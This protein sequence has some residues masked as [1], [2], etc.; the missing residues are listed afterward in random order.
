[1]NVTIVDEIQSKF[2]LFKKCIFMIK[3]WFGE[4]TH[5]KIGVDKRD[6]K[7]LKDFEKGKPKN[8]MPYKTDFCEESEPPHPKADF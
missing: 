2:T 7:T 4:N 1:M 3:P 8:L 5:D 6:I